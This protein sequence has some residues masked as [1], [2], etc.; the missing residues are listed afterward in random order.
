MENREN[1]L[2]IWKRKLALFMA[3]F[4]FFSV[5][6]LPF[7][8]GAEINRLFAAGDTKDYFL[9]ADGISIKLSGSGESPIVNLKDSNSV[10]L[11]L[12]S[13][14]KGGTETTSVNGAVITFSNPGD[15]I[16]E[17]TP[18]ND[19]GVTT[20]IKVERTVAKTGAGAEQ[21]AGSIKI[22]EGGSQ[23]NYNFNFIVKA[24]VLIE[25][26]R[27]LSLS[28]PL[29]SGYL[30]TILF[31]TDQESV[32]DLFIPEVNKSYQIKVKH[33]NTGVSASLLDYKDQLDW[34]VKSLGPDP[35]NV[36]RVN[37]ATGEVTALGA[38]F[39]D[40]EVVPKYNFNEKALTDST[41][42]FVPLKLSK[43]QVTGGDFSTFG[44]ITSTETIT[45]V[46]GGTSKKIYTNVVD[47]ADLEWEITTPDGKKEINNKKLEDF[48][49]VTTLNNKTA[50]LASAVEI[51]VKRAG[52]Y[53]ITARLKNLQGYYK[54]LKYNF[55]TFNYEVPL[56]IRNVDEYLNV[57]DEYNIY[58]NTNIG[59][60]SDYNF[61]PETGGDA[62]ILNE[63]TSVV[64][65]KKLGNVKIKVQRKS[66][67]SEVFY[68]NFTIIDTLKLNQN[69]ATIPV[70][71]TLDLSAISTDLA[72]TTSWVWE[73]SAVNVATVE[74]NGLSATVKGIKPGEADITV[75][76]NARGGVTKKA[77]CKVF[78][79]A[80]V[81]GIK[82][83]P[84][85]ETVDVG[86]IVSIK[87]IVE[88]AA[89][90]GV[91]LYWKSS[92]PKVIEIDNEN[93]HSLSNSVTAKAPGT[94]VVMALNKDN[95]VLGSTVIRVKQPIKS[96]S[97]SNRVLEKSVEDKTHQLTATILPAEASGS[98]LNWISTKPDI[99]TVD[100]NGLVTFKKPGNTTIICASA[101]DPKIMDT[102]DLIILKGVAGLTVDKKEISLSVGE[103]YK[104]SAE[105]K[106][107]DASNKGVTFLSL[108]AKVATVS[109]NGLITARA[110]GTAYIMI[111]TLDK[112][113]NET[114]TVKVVQ[115]PTAMKLS[116]ASL[117]LDVGGS[118]V[119]EPTFTP[120]TV[121]DTKIIWTTS[122]GSV[123]KVDSK[124]RVTGVA[125]GQCIIT[126]TSSNGLSANCHVKVNQQ[127]S[128]ISLSETETEISVG[129]ELELEVSFNS[130]DVTNKEVKWK[131]SNTAV[132]SVNK[133]GVVKGL[134]GGMTIITVTSTE[135]GLSATCILT[136]K[137]A[138]TS[139]K[140]NKKS[141]L[142]PIKSKYT[143]VATVEN[144][145]AT[146]K[147]VKWSSSKKSVVSVS[148]K[149][150]I[151]AKKLGTA[152]IKA[153]ATDG[154]GVLAECKVRVIRQSTSLEV[155]PSYLALK[156]GE[157]KKLRA[158]IGPKNATFKKA[159]FKSDNTDVVLIDNKGRL[160]AIGAGKAKILVSV[161]GN[162]NLKQDVV[163]Q[164]REYIPSTGITF[165]TTNLTMGMGDKQ[166]VIY[167]L[168][169]NGSDDKVT[170]NSNNKAAARVN[171][172]GLVTAIA[173]GSSAI[174]ATTTS[175]KTATISV[176]VVGLNF[177]NLE[178]EQYDSYRLS[179]LGDV[180][181]VTW[182]SSNKSIATVVGGN[183]VAKKAGTCNIYAR[184]NGALLTC[185]V[186]VK[187]LR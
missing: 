12:K 42:I 70:G 151:V 68:V 128:S 126:G 3:V 23:F 183:V 143:L 160:T 101:S 9:E 80:G 53:K 13:K 153:K 19:G 73:S 6:P 40:L 162:K 25:E 60:I 132:A 139:I 170:W 106:P 130:D 65:A 137:E 1:F 142:L 108:D 86:K 58:N 69:M 118:F 147:K 38:G 35:N 15:K 113:F 103:T 156:V 36:I 5:L 62:I 182:D 20:G 159:K 98:A 145:Y 167:T 179:V 44:D 184:V 177:Y 46:G 57:G 178:L 88:P 79:R 97:L 81:T 8:L 39:A 41:R 84:T 115:K 141:L 154:S 33:Y 47:V 91:Y 82:L 138:V 24:D 121:T 180:K 76:Y 51:D 116:A 125:F 49:T 134:R 77:T 78:V 99:A 102:C 149:G 157:K 166:S 171:K 67:P 104:L 168:S 174:T 150:E 85:E 93:E 72:S 158:K 32:H 172:K 120:K 173:P 163:V 21:V 161:P 146:K 185:K 64:S 31:S 111:S 122:D 55:V 50:N 95:V 90:S 74:G 22:T 119:L 30:N 2:R 63:A 27:D 109:N 127:V 100:A 144:P 59:D 4:V 28:P 165:A 52:K 164:V 37:Q 48:F 152:I 114:C 105:V 181:N 169:P 133:K 61:I 110:P 16:C 94:A 148:Q 176:T 186:T 54:D 92:D 87:A 66:K 96:I 7:G 71:G 187:D 29:K 26:E 112:K 136:V 83:V 124:G 89:I 135:N 117:V 11:S 131:S 123:A 43:T 34:K 175:G 140:L 45:P 17:A 107:A 75:S 14:P 129:E 10:T 56:I 18:N 155:E